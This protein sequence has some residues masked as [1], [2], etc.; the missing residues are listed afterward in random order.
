MKPFVIVPAT[1]NDVPDIILLLQSQQLP[2]D[3]IQHHWQFAVVAQAAGRVV[4]CSALE[5]YRPYA[6][7]RSVAVAEEWRKSGVGQQLVQ[8]L[9][10]LAHSQQLEAVYLLTETAV[11]YFP[12]FGF[13]VIE[14]GTVPA[15][16]QQSVEFQSACPASAVVMVLPLVH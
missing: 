4:G 9:L 10:I 12:K 11:D 14:R 15:L 16:V 5:L 2:I 3:D 1:A 6:L 8:S 7:L 13:Q